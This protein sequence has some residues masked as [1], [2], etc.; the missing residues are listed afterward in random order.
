MTRLWTVQCGYYVHYA[1]TVTV[2]AD[3]REMALDKA[4]AAANNDPSGWRGTGHVTG[5]FV[6]SFC[7]GANADPWGEGA[8]PVPDRFTE[9]G[10]P[11]LVTVLIGPDGRPAACVE[12]GKARIR[13]LD[14]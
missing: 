14:G 3:T 13:I 4:L 12:G 5:T 1:N 9:R 2:E 10:E 8:Q 11:P 6:D 7:Q